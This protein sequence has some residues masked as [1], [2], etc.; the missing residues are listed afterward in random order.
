MNK[1]GLLITLLF[2]SI[3]TFSQSDTLFFKTGVSGLT[4]NQR[5][6]I[7]KKLKEHK[8]LIE[9][10]IVYGY[11]D[12]TGGNQLNLN[13]SKSRALSVVK[14]LNSKSNQAF[15]VEYYAKGETQKFSQINLS[16]N[17]SAEVV[18]NLKELK[19]KPIPDFYEKS[20]VETQVFNI[21]ASEDTTIRCKQ[22]TVFYLPANA[23]GNDLNTKK[24]TFEVKE[25]YLKSDM[26]LE[27]LSTMSNGKILETQGMIYTNAMIGEDTLELVKDI[28]I[29]TPSDTIMADAK[30]FDGARDLHSDEM[31]WALNNNSVLRSFNISD[32]TTCP[33]YYPGCGGVK[34]SWYDKAFERCDSLFKDDYEARLECRKQALLDVYGYCFHDNRCKFFFCKIRKFFMA[35]GRLPKRIARIKIGGRWVKAKGK[36]HEKKMKNLYKKINKDGVLN[37]EEIQE[38]KNLLQEKVDAGLPLT[39]EEERILGLSNEIQKEDSL[40]RA[41]VI[42]NTSIRKCSLLAD[43]YEEY[44]VDNAKAL[45][46]ALNKPLLDEFGVT[47]MAELMDTLPKV[48]MEKIELAYKENNISYQDY[49]FYVFNSFN[50]GWKNVDCFADVSKDDMI[51]MKVNEKPNDEVDVK[52]VFVDREFVLPG[53]IIDGKNFYFTGIPKGETAWIVGIKYING[54]PLL[55]LH[56]VTTAEKS[57]ELEF[58]EMSLAELKEALKVIDFKGQD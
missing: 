4:A 50:L 47:T 19:Y 52:L 44:G 7:D 35:V 55:A 18:F 34:D 45:T 33:M 53:E 54:Q 20:G 27:N 36:K 22:G 2:L 15:D 28:M 49:K 29:F 24:V 57:F 32:F 5:L 51:S 6:I 56:K 10:V 25:A 13:L 26:V 40:I 48:N 39:V 21:N 42:N 37:I 30:I 31:N 46:L 3:F 23:F 41:G 17:R 38:M 14:Y 12:T 1:F 16:K 58:K 9:K 8:G 43:L 11:S